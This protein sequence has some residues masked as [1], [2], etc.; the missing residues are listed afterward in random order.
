M[1]HLVLLLLMSLTA[2]VACQPNNDADATPA[3]AP[4]T[5]TTTVNTRAVSATVAIDHD[6]ILTQL[7]SLLANHRKVI[8][9]LADETPNSK[10]VT[11][12]TRV[13]QA[14]FHQNIA[15]ETELIELFSQQFN[16]AGASRI[17]ALE[18]LLDFIESD[19]TLY[20]ADRLVF[21]N[22]LARGQSLVASDGSLPAIK[23]HK[24]IKEDLSALDEIENLYNKEIQ[25]IFGRF[26]K[27]AITLKR[28]K[29]SDYVAK[30]KTLYDK[31][32][33]L[34]EQGVILSYEPPPTATSTEIYGYDFPA[35]TLALSFD[36]GP[37]PSYTAEIAA[38][39]KQYNVPAVIFYRWQK[40]RQCR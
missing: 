19:P 40:S 28:E 35:K 7:R 6:A 15:V 13:A 30:L 10:N 9:L 2:L 33:L 17:A 5:A 32:A 8:V 23:L 38:I 36:D 34:K 26:E 18:R 31:D 4:N 24:R 14:Y 1:N 39:L 16:A 11:A 25:N 37:H 22:F 12:V 29:W 3:A 21:R 27:R 20:D